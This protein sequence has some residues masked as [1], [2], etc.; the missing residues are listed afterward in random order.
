[1]AGQP[2][3]SSGRMAINGFSNPIDV[4]VR[5]HSRLRRVVFSMSQEA[6]AEALGLTFQQVQ[7]YERG[8]NRVNSSRLSAFRTLTLPPSFNRACKLPLI[9]RSLSMVAVARSVSMIIAPRAWIFSS[10]PTPSLRLISPWPLT[11]PPPGVVADRL[12]R[13]TR[14]NQKRAQHVWVRKWQD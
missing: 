7:K 9:A 14:C 2:R 5:H 3:K 12:A 11:W 13:C 8:A 1:M 4:H 10:V 6:V